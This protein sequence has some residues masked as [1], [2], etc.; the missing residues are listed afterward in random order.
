LA[1]FL[2]AFSFSF[3]TFLLSD[4]LIA[5]LLDN[6]ASSPLPLSPGGNL[7]RFLEGDWES[8]ETAAVNAHSCNIAPRER[9][10]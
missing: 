6:G 3:C 5:F 9:S 10:W 2:S 7:T 1:S 4:F 8:D